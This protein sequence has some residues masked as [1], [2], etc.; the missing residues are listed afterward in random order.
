MLKKKIDLL[1]FINTIIIIIVLMIKHIKN[2][3]ML[4]L[5]NPIGNI[6]N[7]TTLQIPIIPSNH[8]IPYP[9]KSL[10]MQLIVLSH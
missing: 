4:E 9:L 8:S 1:R 6:N 5:N 10:F 7:K 2:T 3:L